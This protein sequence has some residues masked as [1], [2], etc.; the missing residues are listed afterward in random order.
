MLRKLMKY[1]LRAIFKYWWIVAVSSLGL[2]V[3]G[4]VSLSYLSTTIAPEAVNSEPA[5]LP[6]IL[7]ILGMIASVLGISGFFLA[8]E[9]FVYIR[10]YQGF[11]SDEGYL[12]FTLPVKRRDLLNSRLFSALITSA[13]KLAVV[14][15]DIFILLGIGLNSE[16]FNEQN[17]NALRQALSL[18]ANQL[19]FYLV[20]YIIEAIAILL[21]LSIASTLMI[22]ACISFAAVVVKKHKIFAAIGMYYLVTA[23][24]SFASQILMIVGSISITGIIDA[25]PN[26]AVPGFFALLLLSVAL[27]CGAIAVALYT[28]EHYLLDKKLNLS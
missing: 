14:I 8:T 24:L 5:V 28:V 27:F 6:L 16:L 23:V 20:I 2:S 1:D 17:W 15:V 7:S 12:T 21:A 19:G 25:I 13:T 22:F 4:G 18:A 3:V 10:F 26:G 9:I 11:F